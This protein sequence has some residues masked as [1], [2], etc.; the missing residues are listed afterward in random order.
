MLVSEDYT[1]NEKQ[2][3]VA[4]R[5]LSGAVLARVKSL[6]ALLMA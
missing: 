3:I 4:K 5:V 6:K 1:L 2:Q